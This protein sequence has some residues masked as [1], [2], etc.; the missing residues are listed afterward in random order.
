MKRLAAVLILGF[1]TSGCVTTRAQTPIERPTLEVPPAPPRVIEPVPVPEVVQQP[2]PV[3]ELPPP[4]VVQTP[5]RS[6]R[7]T[8]SRETQKPEP[9]PDPPVTEP[10]APVPA[11]PAPAPPLRTP[12]TAD[13]AATSKEIRDTLNRAQEGLSKVDFQR[14]SEARK[15]SYNDAK[16]F[17]AQAEAAIKTSSFELAKGLASTAEKLAKELQ[18]R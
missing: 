7:D 11:A 3:E 17:I 13:A 14:L 5:R 6:P 16:D 15:V 2:D 10:P 1:L 8:A 18:G 4:P 9:K 12:A